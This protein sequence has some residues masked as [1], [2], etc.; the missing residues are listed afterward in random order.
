MG[1]FSSCFLCCCLSSHNSKVV[2]YQSSFYYYQVVKDIYRLRRLTDEQLTFIES[3]P[4]MEQHKLILIY[5]NA[6]K[7]ITALETLDRRPPDDITVRNKYTT[8]SPGSWKN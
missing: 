4:I 8:R 1:V 5:N 3:L 2:D 7:L 6:L